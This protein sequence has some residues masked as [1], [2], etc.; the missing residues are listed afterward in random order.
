[1]VRIFRSSEVWNSNSA[2]IWDFNLNI[3]APFKI[4]NIREFRKGDRFK[5]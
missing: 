1:M 2:D 4:R 5:I 3:T